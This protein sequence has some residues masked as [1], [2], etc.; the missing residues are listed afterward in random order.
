MCLRMNSPATNRVGNGGCPGPARQ[1]EPNRPARKPQSISAAS[2]TSG[3]RRLMI[4]SRAGSNKSSWRSSRGWL[5]AVPLQR[6]SPS[7]ESRTA[8]IRDP[9]RK[10]TATHNRLSCKIEYLLR[11]NHGHSSIASE[12]FTG[13]RGSSERGKSMYSWRSLGSSCSVAIGWAPIICDVFFP[14]PCRCGHRGRARWRRRDRRQGRLLGLSRPGF[15]AF[16]T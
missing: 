5:M 4:S 9:K 16:R 15:C 2:R 10:K 1:T 13:D 7:K 12:F 3:W 8:Q 14:K 11:S 6:I